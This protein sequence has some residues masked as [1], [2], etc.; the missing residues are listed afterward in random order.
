MSRFFSGQ[1]ESGFHLDSPVKKPVA[2]EMPR[3]APPHANG[4]GEEPLDGGERRTRPKAASRPDPCRA[5]ALPEADA[6][7]VTQ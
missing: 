7:L 6:R 4:A 2:S 1:A 3:C 5:A